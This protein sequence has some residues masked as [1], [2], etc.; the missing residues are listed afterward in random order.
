MI[1]KH[2]SFSLYKYFE[3]IKNLPQNGQILSFFHF[4][5][6]KNGKIDDSGDAVSVKQTSMIVYI[7]LSSLTESTYKLNF[8]NTNSKQAVLSRTTLEFS[9]KVFH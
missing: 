1:L 7:L 4:S 2:I 8:W 5:S 6:L 9:Y 3:S